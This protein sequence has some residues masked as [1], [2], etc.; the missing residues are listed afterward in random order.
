MTPTVKNNGIPKAPMLQD[1]A[2]AVGLHMSTVSLALSGKGTISAATRQRVLTTARALG[3]RPNPLA[4]RLASS[5]SH[6]LV[7]IL[8]SALDMGLST[9]KLVLIQNELTARSLEVP[10]YA[11]AGPTGDSGESHEETHVAQIRQI[12]QQRPRAIVCA[13]SVIHPAVFAELEA[14]QREG[15]IVVSYD[16]PAP[17]E[18]DQ[19]IFDREDNAYQAARHLLEHGHCD[20]RLL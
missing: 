3:Y 7:C 4:Q 1:L 20:H 8:S 13:G 6:S 10:L 9:Q 18:C 14:Y 5:V 2:E 16:I 12:C 17:L 19:V 15:G 11:Y